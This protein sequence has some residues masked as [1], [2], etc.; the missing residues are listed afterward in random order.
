MVSKDLKFTDNLYESV[1]NNC[2]ES[3]VNIAKRVLNSE[4]IEFL[5][6]KTSCTEVSLRTRFERQF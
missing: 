2:C 1:L 6:I 5:R 4:T 3:A